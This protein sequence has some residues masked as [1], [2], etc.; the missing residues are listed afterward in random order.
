MTDTRP[1]ILA[2]FDRLFPDAQPQLRGWLKAA[3]DDFEP[4]LKGYEAGK[5]LREAVEKA[6]GPHT[7][8]VVVIIA[9]DAAIAAYDR[10]VEGEPSCAA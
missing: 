10:A 7:V 6:V 1:D 4:H 8:D 5:K 9:L 2:E 3:L